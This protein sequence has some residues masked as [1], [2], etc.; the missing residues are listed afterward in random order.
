[1]HFDPIFLQ[2]MILPYS[3]M[4]AD[5]HIR[6]D[7]VLTL[8]QDAAGIHS[9][10]MGVSGLDLAKKNLKWV[11]S[12]Y[13]VQ[14][15]DTLKWPQPFEL[16][17][18]RLPWKNL[19]ELRRFSIVNEAGTPLISALGVWVM[20][21]ALN[22][23]PVRLSPHMPPALMARN[24]PDPDLW[25]NDPDLSVWDHQKRFD[26]H[27]FDLDLN[28]HVNNTVYVTWALE[29]LPMSWLL[30]HMPQTLV[31]CFLKESFYPDRVVSK[32][33]VSGQ[34]DPVTTCHGIFHETS[35]EKLAVLTM[36]WK[37]NSHVP[38]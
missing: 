12:R 20:V 27:R 37:K 24:A 36:T 14:V 32:A 4:G 31:I 8:F 26:I 9:H 16:Q 30:R 33:V 1:M 22:A 11:I 5:N 34:A 17:T 38:V 3:V 15:H 10:Q 18:W 6:L 28:Q 29:T 35:K 21:K 23:K 19:Y 7:R 13:Q 2:K 25:P